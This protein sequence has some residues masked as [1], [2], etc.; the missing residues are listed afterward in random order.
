MLSNSAPIS[1][2]HALEEAFF[3]NVDSMIVRRLQSEADSE[4]ARETLMQSTGLHDKTLLDELSQLGVTTEGLIAMR[5]VP[6]VM[7]AWADRGVDKAERQTVIAQALRVG[8]IDGSVAAVLLE[9]W[10]NQKPP[11]KILDAW[12]RYMTSELAS[13]STV[14]KRRLIALM[15]EQMT[16]VANSSGGHFGIGKVT[17]KEQQLIDMLTD[18]LCE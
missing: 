4:D 9:H 10:L 5:L 16:A 17:V 1:A 18:V 15:E 8:V 2:R 13:M 14:A 11:A 12:R 7:V 3:R 6:L